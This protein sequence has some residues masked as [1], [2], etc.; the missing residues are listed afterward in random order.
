MPRRRGP[1]KMFGEKNRSFSRGA[2][3]GGGVHVPIY[4]VLRRGVQIGGTI[5]NACR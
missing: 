1:A 5:R 4:I 2:R 3:T